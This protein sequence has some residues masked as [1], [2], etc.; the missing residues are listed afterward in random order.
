MPPSKIRQRE[1]ERFEEAWQ[2]DVRRIDDAARHG[3]AD[4]RWPYTETVIRK[5]SEGAPEEAKTTQKN[6]GRH[7]LSVLKHILHVAGPKPV[8]CNQENRYIKVSGSKGEY[9]I[10]VYMRRHSTT[11]NDV[12]LF[13]WEDEIFTIVVPNDKKEELLNVINLKKKTLELEEQN[14]SVTAKK[15]GDTE[16]TCAD[17]V[18]LNLRIFE[19]LQSKL[20]EEHPDEESLTYRSYGN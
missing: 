14:R 11:D 10:E 16:Y 12:L 6:F 13:P 3:A 18:Q 7:A 9:I 20:R 5:E 15:N 2:A 8:C 17:G 19:F 4:T 1:L